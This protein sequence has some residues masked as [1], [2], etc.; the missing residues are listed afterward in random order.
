[1]HRLN[2]W[3]PTVVACAIALGCTDATQAPAAGPLS[4]AQQGGGAL[5]CDFSALRVTATHYFGSQLAKVNR[6]R[7]DGMRAA[8]GESAAGRALGFDVLAAIESE[9]AAG[10]ANWQDAGSLANGLLVCMFTDPADLPATF[11]EDFS[12]AT[13]PSRH[14]AFAVRGGAS[15]AAGPV[16]N[17]P[18][19][20]PFSGLAPPPQ[21]TW[22]SILATNP[23]PARVLL[24]GRPGPTSSTYDW[25]A[26]PRST[27]F[28]PSVHAGVCLDPD[29]ATTSLLEEEHVGLLPFVDFPYLVPGTCSGVASTGATGPAQFARRLWRSGLELFAPRNAWAVRA[30]GIG[31]STGEIRS[32][33]GAFAVGTATLTFVGEPTDVRAGEAIAPAV[34]V[35]AT[36]AGTDTPIP[37]VAV[38]VVAVDNNGTPAQL[39]GGEVQITDADGRATF[40]ALI[41]VKP[42]GYRLVASGEVG[43]RESIPVTPTTSARFNVRP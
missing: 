34:V 12:V 28:V 43:G 14:G 18:T 37:N 26:A 27:A 5:T 23:A 32:L 10:N 24:Y 9:V 22:A 8:G 13:D 16:L 6:D 30:G 33:F 20:A 41:Q 19:T 7:I 36:V 11:P 3:L 17:R 2:R 42:G 25:K 31:G 21:H 39:L 35:R 15:D 40:A 29:I 38:T 4:A 1:M